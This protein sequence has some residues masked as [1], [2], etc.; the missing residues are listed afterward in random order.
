MNQNRAGELFELLMENPD[1]VEMKDNRGNFL[2]HYAVNRGH[3]HIIDLL[4]SRGAGSAYLFAFVRHEVSVGIR[5]TKSR[6]AIGN[7]L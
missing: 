4:V 7:H 1:L 6:K 2:I 3:L 5:T